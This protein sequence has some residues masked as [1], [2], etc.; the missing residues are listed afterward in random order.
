MECERCEGFTIRELVYSREQAR[1]IVVT[2]CY[3]CG[4]RFGE[5]VI[6]FHHSQRP[7]P[8]PENTLPVFRGVDY[9]LC[10][11]IVY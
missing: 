8:A 10:A 9:G 2:R 4:H 11:S 1:S 6:D 3:I 5:P 7:E